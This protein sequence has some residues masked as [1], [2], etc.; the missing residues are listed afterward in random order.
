M[1]QLKQSFQN[2][3]TIRCFIAIE[4]PR[5]I[6]TSIEEY[7]I[8]LRKMSPAIRWVNAANIHITLKF[9]GEI[10]QDLLNNVKSS[11]KSITEVIQP[12]EIKMGGSGA[13]PN[14]KR[15]RVIWLG[16]KSQEYNKLLG[17]YEW[18]ENK[19]VLLGFEKEQRR[20]TPHLTVGRIKFPQNL[21]DLFHYMEQYPFPEK[22]FIVKEIVLMQSLLKP[23]GAEY[24]IIDKY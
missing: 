1:Q 2:E 12:F 5:E 21:T 6:K 11:L 13:F 9:L 10:K 3:K 4:I 22:Q 19:L 16:L 20:F 17:I 24:H 14:Q 23:S 7:L 8:Q 15:P 18:I